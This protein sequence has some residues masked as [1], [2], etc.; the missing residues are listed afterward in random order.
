ML[1]EGVGRLQQDGHQ[2]VVIDS[3]GILSEAQMKGNK[4]VV[5]REELE[6]YLAKYR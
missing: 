2:V 6:S 4:R 5:V 1:F 3:E